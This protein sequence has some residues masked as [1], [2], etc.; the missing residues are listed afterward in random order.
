MPLCVRGQFQSVAS[1]IPKSRRCRTDEKSRLLPRGPAAKP[2][3]KKLGWRICLRNIFT[4]KSQSQHPSFREPTRILPS[5]PLLI[6]TFQ[7]QEQ[8]SRCPTTAATTRWATMA[9]AS[10]SPPTTYP[11]TKTRKNLTMPHPQRKRR[12]PNRRRSL[13][14]RLR[15]QQQQQPCRRNRHG[16]RHRPLLRRCVAPPTPKPKRIRLHRLHPRRSHRRERRRQ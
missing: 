11:T 8:R 5:Q 7:R 13:P 15:H 16:P 2:K 9:W 3:A 6:S 14:R 4:R 10:E 1:E 12:Q